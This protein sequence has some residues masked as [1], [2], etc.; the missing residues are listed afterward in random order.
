MEQLTEIYFKSVGRGQ[1]LLLNVAPDKT[2]HFTAEDIARIEEFSNAINNT[3]DE[4]LAT[5]DTTTAEASSVRGNSMNFS[6]SKVLDDD[7]DSYW[8]MDDGQ[9]TGS[10]T[11]DLGEEKTIQRWVTMHGEAGGDR[12]CISG[13]R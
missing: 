3:F 10:I 4:N 7:H 12:L 6:A 8:T 9:T 5:P 11:I 1:P 13:D 2:G